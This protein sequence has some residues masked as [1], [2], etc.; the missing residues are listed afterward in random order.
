MSQSQILYEITDR[1]GILTLNR[2]E[3]MNAFGG[4]M[5]EDLL[6]MLRQAEADKVGRLH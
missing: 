3:V 1:V 5:R 4:T 2:P 6:Q